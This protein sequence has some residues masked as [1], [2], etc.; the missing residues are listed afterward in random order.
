[1]SMFKPATKEKRKLRMALVSYEGQGKTYSALAIARGLVGTAGKVALADSEG[2]SARIYADRFK[3]DHVEME[4]FSPE[5]YIEA[6]KDAQ[7]SGYDALIIDSL[8]HEWMGSGGV[9]ALVD[10]LKAGGGYGWDKASP[11][12]QRVF[13]AII[14]SKIHVIVTMRQ[15]KAYLEDVDHRGKKVMRQVGTEPVQREGAEFEFDLIGTI[16]EAVMTVS[17]SRIQTMPLGTVWPVPGADVAAKILEDLNSGADPGERNVAPAPALEAAASRPMLKAPWEQP[18][19]HPAAPSNATSAIPVF[20]VPDAP[21]AII[22]SK[23]IDEKTGKPNTLSKQPAIKAILAAYGGSWVTFKAQGGRDAHKVLNA[24]GVVCEP[25]Q[26]PRPVQEA[27]SA[28]S[29]PEEEVPPAAA[30]GQ[31]PQEVYARVLPEQMVELQIAL[32]RAPDHNAAEAKVSELVAKYGFTGWDHFMAQGGAW[33]TRL[34]AHVEQLA[35]P[36]PP[37]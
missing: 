19:A 21:W 34:V 37:A 25:L 7:E 10:Q 27:P 3:F 18:A 28:P 20:E 23:I 35:K 16:Q 15:K 36:A 32:N 11:R 8:S 1:M 17:K 30:A 2:G 22:R 26:P 14:R 5:A 4:T 33:M 31:K 24:L 9:L 6:I 13:E 12:H 29:E